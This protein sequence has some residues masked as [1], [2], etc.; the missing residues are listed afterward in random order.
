MP[1]RQ[2]L[3]LSPF[4]I[5]E[6]MTGPIHGTMLT[7]EVSQGV[8][9]LAALQCYDAHPPPHHFSLLSSAVEMWATLNKYKT[10]AVLVGHTHGAST[11][12][13]NGTHGGAW[14][15]KTAGYID[16]INAPAT[17]KEDGKHNP[18]P[19][20]FMVLEASMLGGGVGSFR[21]AQRVGSGWGNVLSLKTFS[22]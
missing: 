20:E 12:S 7:R 14:G 22:C 4:S 19:S 11:Y 21:V 16:V 6:W 18:L 9:Q 8:V 2:A 3:W 5:M 15:E 1:V 17:Q 13:Y 10:L